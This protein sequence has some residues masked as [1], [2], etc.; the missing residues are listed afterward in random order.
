MVCWLTASPVLLLCLINF[1]QSFNDPVLFS[2]LALIRFHYYEVSYNL[3][4]STSN[5]RC[6]TTATTTYTFLM[7]SVLCT[8]QAY[9]SPTVQLAFAAHIDDFRPITHA[10][11]KLSCQTD[12]S[13]Y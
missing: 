9:S 2:L 3:H 1:K 5:C 12:A 11:C 13:C 10:Y 8:S 6:E 4:D 7:Y